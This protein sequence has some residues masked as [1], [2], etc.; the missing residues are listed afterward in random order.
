MIIHKQIIIKVVRIIY[1]VQ[2]RKMERRK[3]K[4]YVLGV[5]WIG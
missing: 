2:V 4:R 3:V 5:W 1:K